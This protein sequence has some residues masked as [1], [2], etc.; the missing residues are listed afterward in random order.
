MIAPKGFLEAAV[1]ENVIAG[2]A[3]QRR[4][5]YQFGIPLPKG[6][7]GLANAGIGPALSTGMTSLIPPTMEINPAG[8]VSDE[9]LVDGVRM[10]FQFT[11]GTEA[12]AEMKVY[13]PAWKIIDMAENAN[14]TQHNILTPRGA[15]R[16]AMRRCGPRG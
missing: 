16:G 14:A 1:G 6:A 7:D 9:M 13:F 12:P 10:I 11:P 3:M 15:R 8:G 2:P 5:M 4:A